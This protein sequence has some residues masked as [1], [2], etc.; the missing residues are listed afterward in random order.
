MEGFHV[1]NKG[2]C[3]DKLGPL[4][5][6]RWQWIKKLHILFESDKMVYGAK[7]AS[8]TH[9]EA[10][11]SHIVD[12][13]EKM[14]VHFQIY[15]PGKDYSNDFL[16]VLGDPTSASLYVDQ[17]Y[18]DLV[19]DEVDYAIDKSLT[20]GELDR[21]VGSIGYGYCCNE[22]TTRSKAKNLWG[23]YEP[24]LRRDTLEK[25]LLHHLFMVM[26]TFVDGVSF[27]WLAE[28]N[29]L[30]WFDNKSHWRTKLFADTIVEGNKCEAIHLCSS[31]LDSMCGAHSDD[32]NPH[33]SNLPMSLLVS[34][35]K[36][37]GR[38]RFAIIGYGRKSICGSIAEQKTVIPLFQA[39]I[40]F[41]KK[42]P[43]HLQTFK[44][45]SF[46]KG[47]LHTFSGLDGH[48][49]IACA[50]NL[51]PQSFHQIYLWHC[52][53][54]TDHFGLG[55]AELLSL[56]TTFDIMGKSHYLFGV[57]C[58]LLISSTKVRNDKHTFLR[59][60]GGY[61]VGYYILQ[62]MNCIVPQ[63]PSPPT[64]FNDYKTMKV[65]NRKE[66]DVRCQVK[67]AA[68]LH[69]FGAYPDCPPDADIDKIY[70]QCLSLLTKADGVGPLTGNHSIGIM[71]PLGLLPMWMKDH[72]YIPAKSRYMEWFA[73]RFDLGKFLTKG[74]LA[75]AECLQL[76]RML[77]AAIEK[78]LN[79]KLSMRALENLMCK[80][81][82]SLCQSAVLK[83][84]YD[85][86]FQYMPVVVYEGSKY[87]IYLNK[88]RV[89][90]GEGPLI[91]NVPIGKQHVNRQQMVFELEIERKMPTI[92]KLKIYEP[93]KQFLEPGVGADTVLDCENIT[94]YYKLPKNDGELVQQAR[95]LLKNRW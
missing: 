87:L 15:L 2:N 65:P 42:V 49:S 76:M 13:L 62:L 30:P 52:L 51:H 38:R 63:I 56:Q 46:Q 9:Y 74:K 80:T 95:T 31:S 58:R 45:D 44:R 28:D 55:F 78:Q 83:E 71:A 54:M 84:W 72:A 92:A 85:T 73:K 90:V 22:N 50:C 21:Q 14:P 17:I 64:R 57:A 41:L 94:D 81:Y 91:K 11:F 20:S 48:G 1:Q 5:A 59:E 40:D 29:L 7:H 12:A 3:L 25:T 53:Q 35:S 32:E 19:K 89:V 86:T 23:A 16:V 69:I 60:F 67:L 8:C 43:L 39:V 33:R 70:K 68:V 34:V 61:G 75:D 6:H 18:W 66:W 37:I 4:S 47:L 93:P 82:R 36:R 88:E 77:Q 24:G 79:I 10:T 26:T 27:P